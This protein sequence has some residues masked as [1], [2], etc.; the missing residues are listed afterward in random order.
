M[1]T[2]QQQKQ[3]ASSETATEDKIIQAE[4]CKQLSE[5]C[6]AVIAKIKTKRAKK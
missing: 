6:D 2:T 3:E 1:T 4:E 5:K